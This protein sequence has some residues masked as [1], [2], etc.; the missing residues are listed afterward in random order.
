MKIEEAIKQSRFPD[1]FSKAGVNLLYS[2][3]WLMNELAK[4]LKPF[5]LTWQQFNLMRIVRGQKGKPASLKTISE[6]MIDGQ[7]NTSRLVDKLVGKGFV[8]R[9]QCS[10]DR[11]QLDICLSDTGQDVLVQASA[12][13]DELVKG[14]FGHMQEQRL[15]DLNNLLDDLRIN[16]TI[17]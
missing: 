16:E 12:E 3:S 2:A 7:S 14:L 5:D 11:R 15:Y 9:A 8:T 13:V 6:R 4:A 1:E 10:A 17:R